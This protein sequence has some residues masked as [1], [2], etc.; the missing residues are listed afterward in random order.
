[1]IVMWIDCD[2]KT[3]NFV[4]VA[5]EKEIQKLIIKDRLFHS[6]CCSVCSLCT[7][8]LCASEISSVHT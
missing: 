2:Y 6:L 4:A 3:E 7:L 8:S 5:E 1:M